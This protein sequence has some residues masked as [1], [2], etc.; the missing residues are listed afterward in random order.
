MSIA[1]WLLPRPK[2]DDIKNTS[3]KNFMICVGYQ[4]GLYLIYCKYDVIVSHGFYDSWFD[5][6]YL[7]YFCKQ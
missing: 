1:D 4:R 7:L 5:P 3:E 6:L 2:Y